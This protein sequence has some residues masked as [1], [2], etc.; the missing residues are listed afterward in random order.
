MKGWARNNENSPASEQNP[1]R[2]FPWELRLT[3]PLLEPPALALQ[4]QSLFSVLHSGPQ[5]EEAS[6]VLD[7]PDSLQRRGAGN[8]TKVKILEIFTSECIHSISTPVTRNTSM[9]WPGL[10]ELGNLGLHGVAAVGR[11]GNTWRIRKSLTGHQVHPPLPQRNTLHVLT[12]H[13]A[14]HSPGFLENLLS[15]FN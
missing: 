14:G 4:K 9:A 8:R 6:P 13:V 15:S 1:G 7:V 2:S 12:S 5:A 3:H 10:A 11:A